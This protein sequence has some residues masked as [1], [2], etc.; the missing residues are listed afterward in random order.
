[1]DNGFVGV[2]SFT[3]T[4]TDPAG[5]TDIATVVIEVQASS[6]IQGNAWLDA[7]IDDQ[8]DSNEQ[9][10]EGW[11]IEVLLN[12][13]VVATVP[14]A[15]DG[16]Y[17]V[18]DLLPGSGYELRLRHP[19]SAAVFGVIANINLPPG[20]TVIDQNL[21]IDPSGVVYDADSRQPIAGATV[22]MS[23]PSGVLPAS[24]LLPGQQDQV[25]GA[26]GYY[27]FDVLVDADPAC[28]SGATYVIAVTAPTGFVDSASV[29]ITPAPGPFDPTGQSNPLAIAPQPTAPQAGD[30]TLYY[31]EFDLAS[32]DPNVI[33]NHIPLDPV[34]VVAAV[35]VRKQADRQTAVVGDLVLYRVTV[36]NS[37]P[38]VTGMTLRDQPPA[39]FSYVPN[40]A[41]RIQPTRAPV[42]T[43]GRLDLT[44]IDVGANATV[45]IQ[46]ALR[47]TPGVVRGDY[48]NTVAPFVGGAP[49]G[50]SASATVTVVADPDF[51]ETTVIGTV[52]GDSNGNGIQDPG[53]SGIPGVRLA[54]VEGLLVETDA[55]GRYHLA[56]LDG[57][58]RDRGRNFIIKVDPATLPD[59]S[60]FT[61]ENPRVVRVTQGV[62]APVNFGVSPGAPAFGSSSDCCRQVEV[63]IAEVFFNEGSAEVAPQFMPL[64]QE[65]ADRLR[66]TGGGT[67]YIEGNA[68]ASEQAPAQRRA[69]TLTPLFDTRSAV[70][71][72]A[73]KRELDR[74]AAEWRGASNLLIETTGHT[75]N[76]R[77][78]SQHRDQYANN[79]AL[80]EARAQA[81]A[82]YLRLALQASPE[83]VRVSG[84][85]ADQPVAS[86]DTATGRARNRRVEL[87][88]SGIWPNQ[89]SGSLSR[90]R[91][92]RVYEI[93]R[94]LLGEEFMRDVDVTTRP[95]P[96]GERGAAVK[97]WWHPVAATLLGLLV[98]DAHAQQQCTLDSCRTDDGYVIEVVDSD[99][100]PSP[101]DTRKALANDRRADIGGRFM[102]PVIG[103]GRLWVTEDPTAGAPRLAVYAPE[104]G[105]AAA[106]RLH[107]P[108]AF[109]VYS[110][111]PDFISRGQVEVYHGDDIDLIEPVATIGFE[112][113]VMT[114]VDWDGTGVSRR[115]QA[116]DELYYRVRVY[117]DKGRYD[118]THLNH[119]TLLTV[120]D[121][122]EVVAAQPEKVGRQ[123][124]APVSASRGPLDGAVLTLEPPAD[125]MDR[126][127]QQYE[128]TPHFDTR[129]A[130]L[131]PA[132]RAALDR[133]IEQWRG[134]ADDIRIHVVGHT[135]SRRIAPENRHEYANNQVLS[136]AR[137][138]SVVEYLGRGLDLSNS[139]IVSEG[140]AAREPVASNASAA[141]RARN[142]RVEV[143]ISGLLGAS[144]QTGTATATLIDPLDNTI[145]GV[146]ETLEEAANLM[147]ARRGLTLPGSK[148]YPLAELLQP[149]SYLL[150]CVYGQDQLRVQR[151]PV[152]GSRVRIHGDGVTGAGLRINGQAV[153]I[154]DSGKYAVEYLVPT[155]KH[156]YDVEVIDNDGFAR[157]RENIPVEVTGH[158]IFVVALADLTLSDNSVSGNIEPLSADDRYDEDF[159]VEGRLAFYLKGKI[160]GKYLVT[161]Q[162]DSQEEEIGDLFSNLGEKDPRSVLRR[163]DPDRYYPVYGDDST[164]TLDTNTQGRF[165]L[166][167]DW[168]RS[169]AM[170]GNFHTGITGN[171]FAQ[172]NRSLYGARYQHESLNVT[173]KGL[174]RNEATLFVS[175][176]Q[177][178]FGHSEFLG[179]G[180]SL[181]Y[182]RHQDILPGSEKAWVEIRDRDTNRVREIMT[183]VRGIDY[184]VDEIQGRLILAQPLT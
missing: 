137:A 129:K 61:T 79:R 46:Y 104:V 176:A 134:R 97:R 14:V 103:G 125:S 7:D 126:E 107:E 145:I 50:N 163:L 9:P 34:G 158:E 27:R 170:W 127:R 71:K 35:Q 148:R 59:G 51:E 162:L 1:P 141:G 169:S 179:T 94:D 130:V 124:A 26:D 64:L 140:R 66:N 49:I 112:P 53:E 13:V 47:V 56:G 165:Y 23:G 63:K 29:L 45:T 121:Y 67:L 80:S 48:I 76:I 88:I 30:S 109:Y 17:T 42:A 98:N 82:T 15:A 101:N 166:R 83:Q 184:E 12:G 132:D 175:E 118:E 138:R 96:P 11:Q 68:T 123:A 41:R 89:D 95:T 44:G 144:G 43:S 54:T 182:L 70:L 3:Y 92:Q 143:S 149:S 33:N 113:A 111:Y 69:Y 57:G 75:D 172:Y 139:N 167:A 72:Q 25:T 180:G 87:A 32:G 73:D 177:T 36:T 60:T 77:I 93:L 108:V 115:L 86:N 22:T 31:L 174:P 2:D 16:S 81:V 8:F 55:F 150:G 131:K 85:G 164:T 136:E 5:N 161:A 151:I 178:A 62:M 40:S 183:L 116:G 117:D 19:A 4:I 181:Y 52:F 58:T 168:D 157:Q 39:G 38:A 122:A 28:P 120:E 84:A 65:L 6:T 10:L 99:G 147:D 128:L 100:M 20:T 160:R 155:G 142:R 153:P 119:L 74:I 18:A 156:A 110:N 91:A 152:N 159:L 105:A 37:G 21:P 114:R 171:E 133:I 106:D 78:A 102:V 154:D 146:G 90:Q 173:G 24:C 135:D